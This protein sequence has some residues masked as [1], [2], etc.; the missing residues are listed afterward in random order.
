MAA[1]TGQ[2]CPGL[3]FNTATSRYEATL[4]YSAANQVCGGAGAYFFKDGNGVLEPATVS[5]TA[6]DSTRVEIQPSLNGTTRTDKDPGTYF[7]Y[8]SLKTGN[9]TVAIV[10]QVTN[11]N[12]SLSTLNGLITIQTNYNS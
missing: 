3:V 7:S 2:A 10:F 6:Y 5:H 4:Q 1:Q 8:R 11:T 9:S 12:G